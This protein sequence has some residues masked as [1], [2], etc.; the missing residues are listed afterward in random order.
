M[1]RL[2]EM[3]W[4][5]ETGCELLCQAFGPSRMASVIEVENCNLDSGAATLTRPGENLAHPVRDLTKV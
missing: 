3:P 2:S 4:S 1:H 5:S